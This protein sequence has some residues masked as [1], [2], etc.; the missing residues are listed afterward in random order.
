MPARPSASI[1]V[2]AILAIAGSALALISIFF[3][4]LGMAMM[5]S[6]ASVPALPPAV[7]AVTTVSLLL[8]AGLAVFGIFTGVGLL[9]LKNWAR[10]SILVFSGLATAVSSLTII[11]ATFL[12]IPAAPEAGP[13]MGA[14]IKVFIMIFY[15]IPL[16]IGIMVVGGLWI[17]SSLSLVFVLYARTPMVL[18]GH[19][20]NRSLSVTLWVLKSILY[21][22]AGVGLF[23]VKPLESFAF[24]RIADL[25]E[26]QRHRHHVESAL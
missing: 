18:F 7:Q 3:A 22:V 16:V 15:G 1:T 8:F 17:L 21:V 6:A 25:R 20:F 13:A 19:P 9:R 12:P 14:F 24:P 4:A 2:A 10:I 11:F 26:P 5:R 23:R